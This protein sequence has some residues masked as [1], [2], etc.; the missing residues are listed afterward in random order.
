MRIEVTEETVDRLLRMWT[1]SN[2][3]SVTCLR[4]L[5]RRIDLTAAQRKRLLRNGLPELPIDAVRTDADGALRRFACRHHLVD[6]RGGD[7]ISGR[8]RG[9]VRRLDH[10]P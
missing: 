9:R 10:Q 3:A 8:L 2:D 4:W 1:C 5:S 7:R 6:G